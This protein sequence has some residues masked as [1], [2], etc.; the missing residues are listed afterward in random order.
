MTRR[1]NEL[2]TLQP[3]APPQVEVAA[4]VRKTSKDTADRINPIV[5]NRTARLTL[6]SVNTPSAFA[7][8][9]LG[10]FLLKRIVR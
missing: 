10:E 7:A 1:V 8:A 2:L 4:R 6:R 3:A 9:I 5:Q